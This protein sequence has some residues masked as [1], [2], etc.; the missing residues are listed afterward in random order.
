MKTIDSALVGEVLR[1]AAG[2]H[3]MPYFTGEG[4]RSKADGS[5]VT[6]A[7]VASQRFI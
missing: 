4:G 2:R 1:G 6:Q 3:V 7:D 5:V